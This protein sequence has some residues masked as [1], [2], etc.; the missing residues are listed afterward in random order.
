MNDAGVRQRL[1]ESN[2]HIIKEIMVGTSW[3]SLISILSVCPTFLFAGIGAGAMWWQ[4]IRRSELSLLCLTVLSF[5]VG[6]SLFWGKLRYRIPVESSIVILAAFG[7]KHL[8][9]IAR[10]RR[11]QQVLAGGEGITRR[12]LLVSTENGVFM[13]RCS[14]DMS[15]TR[16]DGGR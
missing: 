6:Y 13:Q 15:N 4:K 10:G 9:L 11:G 5:A 8:W 12:K 7:M 3:T 2:S 1:F 14:R 16:G